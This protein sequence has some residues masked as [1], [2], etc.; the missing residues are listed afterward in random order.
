VNTATRQL[1]RDRAENR[2][3]YCR[4]PQSTI[5]NRLHVE[6][7]IARQHLGHDEPDN[8]ALACDLCNV[9]KGPNL[10]AI[11]PATGSIVQ[12]FNPRLD[13]WPEHFEIMPD[14]EI[15][16]RTPRG[17]A[18]ARLLQMNTRARKILRAILI[19]AGEF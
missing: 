5:D 15:I 16:G 14:G 10:S 1:V 7:I 3:E 12:L 11:D 8:L 19:A 6:H 4:V 17:R 13:S 18:T 2:C 9:Q